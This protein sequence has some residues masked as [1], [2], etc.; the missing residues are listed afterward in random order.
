MNNDWKNYLLQ[1]NAEQDDSGL[2]IF[3]QPYVDYQNTAE[4]DIVCDLSY[5][6]TIV[7]AGGD[8]AEFI[9]GQFTNDVNKVDENNS[10]ISGFCNNKGRMIANYRLFQHQQNYFI[11]IRSDL[12][13]RSINHLQN[14]LLR[15]EVAIQDISE[16]LIHIGI[17][18]K[19]AETL[20]D[21]YID[22][23]NTDV[24]SVSSNENY[25][26]IRI[27]GDIPRYEIF[28]S[29]EHA[30]KLWQDLADKTRTVNTAYW[31]YLNIKNGLP[32]IDSHTSEEFVPQM[33]NMEL[34]NGIS[35]EKGCYTGQE[36]VAR[37]HFLGKQ[38]RRTYHINII[39]DTEPKVGEQLAT[40]TSTENQYTGTL[41]T[42][43]PVS[44]NNY[45]ALAVIQIK[46]A[47][48]GKLKL[49]ASDARIDVLGL[50]YSLTAE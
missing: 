46:S 15:A 6:S 13:E 29:F 24:D 25:I 14:Y 45:E 32:F 50:P 28:C 5:F 20:L 18:G 19:N 17:S 22:N 33:A 9:Q 49:K 40:D 42:L 1:N 34:I 39:S 31:D 26:A 3:N 37:T 10:Q 36:I 4:N 8:A 48:E 2:F 43:S 16:Q 38:K 7:I 44:E 30:T 11:S 35:F 12:V 23:L 41:V 21:G 47:E 27:A